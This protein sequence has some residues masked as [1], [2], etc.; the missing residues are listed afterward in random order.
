MGS[1]ITYLPRKLVALPTTIAFPPG[2]T[3]GTQDE[4]QN[5]V[6]TSGQGAAVSPDD[7]GKL[8]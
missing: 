1:A 7:R 4:G 8:S 3:S 5:S 2:G 6:K